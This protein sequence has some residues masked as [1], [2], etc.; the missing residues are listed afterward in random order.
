MESNISYY[1]IA[2]KKI[3]DPFCGRVVRMRLK[4]QYGGEVDP[5]KLSKKVAKVCGLYGE[6]SI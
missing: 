4:I 1:L 3:F 5:I 2:L 6:F